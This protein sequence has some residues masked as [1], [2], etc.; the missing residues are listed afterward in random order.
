M[1]Q[2]VAPICSQF[3]K[4]RLA[5]MMKL[6][7][8]SAMQHAAK[9]H[10]NKVLLFKTIHQLRRTVIFAIGSELVDIDFEF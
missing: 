7:L 4:S 2:G 5:K 1:I 8:L 3:P 6:L 9:L 10:D